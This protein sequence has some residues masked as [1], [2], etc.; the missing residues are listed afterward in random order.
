MSVKRWIALL[1]LSLAVVAGGDG[2]FVAAAQESVADC[3]AFASF[4]EANAYYAENQD[5]AAALDDDGDGTAC[6]VYFGL[7]QRDPQP[8]ASPAA[9]MDI[10]DTDLELFAQQE[11]GELDCEDF[12]TQED[13][14]AALD[15]DPADPNN[16]DPNGDG[17]ACALL[18]SADNLESEAPADVAVEQTAEEDTQSRE[19]RRAARQE[20]RRQGRQQEDVPA[21]ET[22]EVTCADF[23]TQEDAQAAFD[24]DPEGLASLD[25]DGN[26]IACEELIVEE[27]AAEEPTADEDRQARRE[28]R[29]AA[30]E[31]EEAPAAID[32]PV[33]VQVAE[34]IDCADF[35]FQEDAQLTFDEDPSDP[36]NLDPSGDGFACSSLPSAIPTVTQVPR[37]GT[38]AASSLLLGSLAA[39]SLLLGAGAAGIAW[40]RA[41]R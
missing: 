33:P 15:E 24:A 32:E 30:R 4:D 10:S 16:L 25:D 5:A 18:P 2:A 31:A 22:V 14:Q 12:A 3:T 1:V 29:R 28:A 7:E 13:A 26:G 34:D 35:A 6:E 27:P 41:R 21:E 20:E 9:Q 38:G 17:I 23:A 8:A 19:E 39:V 40:Q 11:N 37:T 36:F